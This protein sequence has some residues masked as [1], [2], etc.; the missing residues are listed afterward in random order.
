MLELHS[1]AGDGKT[2]KK[3]FVTPENRKA[4]N[5]K[6]KEVAMEFSNGFIGMS[7]IIYWPGRPAAL[8]LNDPDFNTLSLSLP[9]PF[10]LQV[11]LT[12]Y[13]DGQPVTY[14]CQKRGTP[15]Q[16]VFFAIAFK[17]IDEDLKKALKSRTGAGDSTSDEAED[18]GASDSD[19]D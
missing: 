9:P 11:S 8:T 2:R 12:K 13:W 15:G 7:P 5:L 16:N 18:D 6:D 3:H 4:V 1:E 10:S 14:V 19:V 17:I